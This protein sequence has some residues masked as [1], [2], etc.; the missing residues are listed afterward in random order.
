[1]DQTKL[2]EVCQNSNDQFAFLSPKTGR[3]EVRA[4]R[5]EVGLLDGKSR[6]RSRMSYGP[7]RSSIMMRNILRFIVLYSYFVFLIQLHYI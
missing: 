5:W 3:W 4:G 2:P 6:S 7:T 1:M